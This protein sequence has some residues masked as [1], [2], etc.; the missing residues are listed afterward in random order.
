VGY[1]ALPKSVQETGVQ[2]WA[3]F[4]DTWIDRAL[5]CAAEIVRRQRAGKFWPPADKAWPQSY[6]ELFLGDITQT[7]ELL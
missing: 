7:V 2:L 6:D 5:E 1:F 4:S 3:D